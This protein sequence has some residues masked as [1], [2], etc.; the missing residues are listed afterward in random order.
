MAWC[1]ARARRRWRGRPVPGRG[2]CRSCA[3]RTSTP[4]TPRSSSRRCDLQVRRPRTAA[5]PGTAA[6]GHRGACVP[7]GCLGRRSRPGRRRR[8]CRAG[9][10]APAGGVATTVAQHLDLVADL[11]ADV[12]RAHE[13]GVHRVQRLAVGDGAHRR[14]SGL[15]DEV[16]AVRLGPRARLRR[17]G[18]REVVS[19]S[20][21]TSVSVTARVNHSLVGRRG[22]RSLTAGRPS[23]AGS[24]S[25]TWSRLTTMLSGVRVVIQVSGSVPVEVALDV[26]HERRHEDPVALGHVDV[27]RVALA[28]VDP[29]AA[30]QHVA[31]GL[32]LAVVVRDRPVAGLVAAPARTRSSSPACAGG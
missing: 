21:S 26:R 25:S 2:A 8:A 28:E 31:A 29:R 6:V 20:A 3:R 10:R 19:P 5:S 4:A 32:R 11:G 7:T 9:R 22:C 17:R 23:R 27:V 1:G 18:E 24:A 14:R 15:G 16:A 12:G 30:R 13:V